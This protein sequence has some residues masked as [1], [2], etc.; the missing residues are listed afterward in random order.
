MESLSMCQSLESV[1]LSRHALANCNPDCLEILLA[2]GLEVMVSER[3]EGRPNLL[4]KNQFKRLHTK[5]KEQHRRK[6]A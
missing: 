5:V 6:Q 2:M 3:S 4:E 1:S